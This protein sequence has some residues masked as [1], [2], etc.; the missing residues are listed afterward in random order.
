MPI[1]FGDEI[2]ES[3]VR[4]EIKDD[5]DDELIKNEIQESTDSYVSEIQEKAIDNLNIHRKE[6]W[7]FNE[8]ETEFSRFKGREINVDENPEF[9][10]QQGIMDVGSTIIAVNPVIRNYRDITVLDYKDKPKK[11]QVQVLMAEENK[12]HKWKSKPRW[13]RISSKGL[14]REGMIHPISGSEKWE[15]AMRSRE[16]EKFT[17]D[18]KCQEMYPQEVLGWKEIESLLVGK[19]LQ[20]ALTGRVK[21]LYK[22]VTRYYFHGCYQH[23][24]CMCT[25]IGLGFWYTYSQW[26]LPANSVVKDFMMGSFLNVTKVRVPDVLPHISK[27]NIIQ[28]KPQEVRK[29]VKI[30]DDNNNKMKFSY[31]NLRFI[32][33][34]QQ[35]LNFQSD[36]YD[37]WMVAWFDITADGIYRHDT[38]IF[39]EFVWLSW[40]DSI[41]SRLLTSDD[42][43]NGL[44]VKILLSWCTCGAW[45]MKIRNGKENIKSATARGPKYRYDVK[46]NILGNGL[47]QWNYKFKAMVIISCVAVVQRNL[48]IATQTTIEV[49]LREYIT[50][51]DK[52]PIHNASSFMIVC[53]AR[54]LYFVTCEDLLRYLMLTHLRNFVK[55]WASIEKEATKKGLIM[56]TRDINSQE[57]QS[58]LQI[59]PTR[60]KMGVRFTEILFSVQSTNVNIR[61]GRI[62]YNVLGPCLY[63]GCIMNEG[64]LK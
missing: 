30:D 4:D 48:S 1:R 38:C 45:I 31:E 12:W 60:K 26:F 41:K 55:G 52:D 3:T 47:I 58:R 19:R 10:D 2:Q 21:Q 56:V 22:V 42:V 64:C 16:R 29:L 57:A 35:N 49:V 33:C 63:L 5:M 62:Y 46:D 13:S 54:S 7:Q 51:L 18:I 59:S 43:F 34:M 25:M 14:F 8:N 50:N 9:N 20:V 40:I 23:N 44:T 17:L 15:L 39:N 27:K 36:G 53:L 28:G 37:I 24:S 32:N 11:F 6:S 61:V